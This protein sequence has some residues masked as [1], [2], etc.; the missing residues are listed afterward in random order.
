MCFT[1]SQRAGTWSHLSHRGV[2]PQ[3]HPEPSCPSPVSSSKAP[4]PEETPGRGS[5]GSLGS[6]CE[7]QLQAP[8][9]PPN[10]TQYLLRQVGQALPQAVQA[11]DRGGVVVPGAQRGPGSAGTVGRCL[12]VPQPRLSGVQAGLRAGAPARLW[13]QVDCSGDR[14]LGPS[15]SLVPRCDLWAGHSSLGRAQFLGSPSPRVT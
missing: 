5:G 9:L 8:R 3:P 11:G 10:P 1:G 7:T 12:G 14:A 6:P 13:G 2:C 4:Q 15:W